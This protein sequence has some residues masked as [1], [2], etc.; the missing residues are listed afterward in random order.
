MNSE[1]M[2]SNTSMNKLNSEDT[3]RVGECTTHKRMLEAFCTNCHVYQF[4]N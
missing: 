4:Q 2:R 3:L 1:Q